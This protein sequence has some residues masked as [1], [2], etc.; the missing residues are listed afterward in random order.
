MKVMAEG[1]EKS[2]ECEMKVTAEGRELRQGKEDRWARRRLVPVI[3]A[4]RRARWVDLK[5]S[6]RSFRLTDRAM[7]GMV[8]SVTCTYT[9]DEFLEL[10]SLNRDEVSPCWPDWSQTLD[11]VIHLPRRPQVL[12]LQEGTA[13]PGPVLQLRRRGSLFVCQRL[14]L[15]WEG[16]ILLVTPKWRTGKVSRTNIRNEEEEGVKSRQKSQITA[17]AEG[18]GGKSAGEK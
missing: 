6:V 5:P 17:A 14:H 8:T 11:L 4:L 12:G 2:E 1:R 16:C 13:T 18:R 3:P 7:D 9:A 10:E 15:E